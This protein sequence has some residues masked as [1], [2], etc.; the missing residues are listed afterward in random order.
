MINTIV[1]P[2]IVASP[3]ATFV[4]VVFCSESSVGCG[5]STMIDTVVVMVALGGKIGAANCG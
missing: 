5:G 2:I 3:I 1:L 4:I